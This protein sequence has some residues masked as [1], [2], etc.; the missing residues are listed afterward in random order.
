MIV[1]VFTNGI[2]DLGSI[3]GQVIPKTQKMVVD[4]SLVNTQHKVEI[5]RK[6]EQSKKGVVPSH[7]P[8][9]S[10]DRKGILRVTLD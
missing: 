1:R 6:V 5:K 4:D 10:S 2:E 8:W 7:T 9:C 3:P